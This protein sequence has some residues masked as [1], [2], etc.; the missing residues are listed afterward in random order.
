MMFLPLIRSTQSD[1]SK[2]TCSTWSY[3]IF[4]PPNFVLQSKQHPT[5]IC[6]VM[7]TRWLLVEPVTP[8]LTTYKSN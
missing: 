6:S 2:F 3:S 8:S 5:S 7:R 4:Q 1:G